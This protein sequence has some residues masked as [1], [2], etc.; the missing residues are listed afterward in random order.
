MQIR[1]LFDSVA[2]DNRFLTGW[3]VS[4]L[5]DGKVLFDTGEK[6][7]SLF[8]NMQTMGVRISDIKVVV[9]S[10]DHWD[11]RGGLWGILKENPKLKVC[12]CPNFSRRFKNRVKSSGG[13]LIEADQFTQVYKDI[14]S[15]GEV[16]GRY[17][18]KYMPEQ[19]LVLRTKKGIS[20]LTGCAHPG[21][22]RIIENVKRSISGNIYLV[23]G[24]F[25]LM[26]KHKKTITPIVDK[27][28]QLKIKKVAPRHCTGKNAA[29]LFKEKYG[30]D[31]IE[32]KV[33]QTIEI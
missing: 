16:E 9:I 30:G 2:M 23:M 25:H 19:A 21:I 27:F 32:V 1:V 20:V 7:S 17:V 8:R 31:F 18:G 22:I 26:G 15:T 5:I 28:R 14:Y 12:A 3:G 29:E 13:Q 11:H 4:Y 10:H 33:G 24:G 6:S